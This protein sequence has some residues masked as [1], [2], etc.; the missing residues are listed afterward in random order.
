MAQPKLQIIDNDLLRNMAESH[1]TGH[2]AFAAALKLDG[3]AA[4]ASEPENRLAQSDLV[5]LG[6]VADAARAK[7]RKI[8]GEQA[9]QL[10][11]ANGHVFVTPGLRRCGASVAADA[12]PLPRDV[13]SLGEFER[14]RRA[15]MLTQNLSLYTPTDTARQVRHEELVDN[16][17]AVLMGDSGEELPITQPPKTLIP[18]PA[19][20]Y[21]LAYE[22]ATTWSPITGTSHVNTPRRDSQDIESMLDIME[23]LYIAGRADVAA[24]RSLKSDPG[25]LAVLKHVAASG[26]S[27]TPASVAEQDTMAD[28]FQELIDS[29]LTA[30]ENSFALPDTFFVSHSVWSGT[31]KS[32]RASSLTTDSQRALKDKLDGAGIR[33]VLTPRLGQRGVITRVAGAMSALIRIGDA[34]P[35][36]MHTYTDRSGTR[37]I[38]GMRTGGLYSVLGAETVVT[39]FPA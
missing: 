14:P 31:N 12:A 35:R 8:N 30:N 2:F 21:L 32:A 6:C 38:I 29:I 22:R 23:G 13:D 27:Y 28:D 17:Q 34:A 33:L 15:R 3:I 26:V 39:D 20:L 37:S 5:A 1:D 36:L 7:G 24:L 4:D 18:E 9:I 11:Q 10:A 16:F 19:N 25:T